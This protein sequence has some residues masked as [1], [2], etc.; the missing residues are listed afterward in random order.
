MADTTVCFRCR[1]SLM[2]DWSLCPYC[3]QLTS[4][5]SRK[6]AHGSVGA[7]VQP[8]DSIPLTLTAVNPFDPDSDAHSSLPITAE[9]K[10]DTTLAGIGLVAIGAI[11]SIALLRTLTSA[12]LSIDAVLQIAGL[13]VM[14]MI[15][16]IVLTARGKSPVVSILSGIIGGVITVLMAALIGILIFVSFILYLFQDCLRILGKQ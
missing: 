9:S 1:K 11:G 10:R 14:V 2:T 16:G 6:T 8:T 4:E 13:L 7:S 3:G 12:R 15:V 5:N